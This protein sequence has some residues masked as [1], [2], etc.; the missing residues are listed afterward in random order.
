MLVCLIQFLLLVCSGA[1]AL[2]DAF[3]GSIVDLLEL[4]LL[5]DT[6]SIA[7]GYFPGVLLVF[8]YFLDYNVLIVFVRGCPFGLDYI[9]YE[10]LILNRICQH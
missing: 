5:F 1:S 8:D 6:C 7:Y 4:W 3:L 10:K 9:V 2:L